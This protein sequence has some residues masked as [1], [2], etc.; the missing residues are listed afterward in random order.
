MHNIK[1]LL[2]THRLKGKFYAFYIVPEGIRTMNVSTCRTHIICMQMGVSF[3]P[4]HAGSPTGR[5]TE[6]ITY[7]LC[8]PIASHLGSSIGAWQRIHHVNR[9]SVWS[10]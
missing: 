1:V 7:A 3:C 9:V 10:Q 2:K 8:G 5:T 4:I 6:G